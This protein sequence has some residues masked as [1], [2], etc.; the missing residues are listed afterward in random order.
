ML[1]IK[2]KVSERECSLQEA[3]FEATHVY[4]AQAWSSLLAWCLYRIQPD[5][6]EAWFKRCYNHRSQQTT[7]LLHSILSSKNLNKEARVPWIVSGL[8]RH[9]N[10]SGG[11][12]FKDLMYS[13]T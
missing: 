8:S 9:A 12:W 11:R 5:K 4:T 10:I 2:S 7:G 1:R 13:I 3:H 6:H